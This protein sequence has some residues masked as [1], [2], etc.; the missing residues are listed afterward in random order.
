VRILIV[1]DE[2]PLAD[3]LKKGLEEE[4]YAVDVAYNGEDGQ[5][6][7][8]NEP[9][10]LMILDIMLPLVDGITI[11]KNIR[12]AG[13]KTPVLMLT[14][15]DAIGDKVSGLDSGADDYMT[16][17]FSFE[18]LLARTRT[19]LRRNSTSKTF[20]I[21]IKNLTLDT[22]T[23]EVQ[24]GGKSIPLSAKEYALLEYMAH[25]RNTVL[26]RTNLT[27]H[28][29]NQDFDLDSNVIDVFI[30]RLRNKIDRGFDEKL[31][32]TM[33]GAGYLLRG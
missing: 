28:L 19:L 32:Q 33:R 8:E 22:A 18:E 3:I 12:K 27:E 23:H 20:I 9:S 16:K 6:L 4:G 26:S 24:R 5:Y 13:I 2:K 30:N 11:L 17:P 21:M 31:I 25:N 15:K 7:A 29:Y 1:E 10:D 14:A